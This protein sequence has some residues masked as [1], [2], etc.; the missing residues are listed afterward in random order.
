[1]G[2]RIEMPQLSS[3]GGSATLASWLVGVGDRV[4]QGEVIAE[5]ET[6]KATVELEAPASGR[7]QALEIAANHKIAGN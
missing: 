4:E 5:L 3:D 2:F 6:D 1:M 7:I